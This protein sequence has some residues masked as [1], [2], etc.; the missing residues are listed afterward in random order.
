MNG[1]VLAAVVLASALAG[2]A[3]AWPIARLGQRQMMRELQAS[4]AAIADERAR[5][6]AAEA[7]LRQNESAS[8]ATTPVASWEW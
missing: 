4:A 8:L 2:G 3:L 6:I 1:F 7:T 5:R